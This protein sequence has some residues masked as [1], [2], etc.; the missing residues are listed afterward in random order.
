MKPSPALE[1]GDWVAV[2]RAPEGDAIAHLT[3]GG[4]DASVNFVTAKASRM[5]GRIAFDSANPPPPSSSFTVGV[6]GIGVDA[7]IPPSRSFGGS[8]P[9]KVTADGTFEIDDILG[10]VEPY[11]VTPPRGWTLKSAMHNGRSLLDA[12]VEFKG[13]EEITGVEI[14]L[15]NRVSE[16]AGLAV[17]EQNQPANGCSVIIFP[18]SRGLLRNEARWARWE[19]TDQNGR[20]VAAGLPAGV[21][22]AIAIADVDHSVWSTAEYLDRFRPQAARVALGDGDKR[23]LTLECVTP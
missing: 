9:G 13:G 14:V 16:I 21:Y 12:P 4:D 1:P 18:E 19:R 11:L 2:F 7:A 15:T 6:R 3:M 8:T 23:K 17:D 20:F 5:A 22:L 10:T